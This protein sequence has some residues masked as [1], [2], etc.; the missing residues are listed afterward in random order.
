MSKLALTLALT[1][2]AL[3][4]AAPAIAALPWSAPATIAN[5]IPQLADPTIA[6][7]GNGHAVL[8]ARL[9]TK[10]DGLPSRGFTRLFGQ[11]A[12][13]SFSGR[14]RLVLAAP[15]AAWG[16]SRLALLRLPLAKGNVTIADLAHPQTSLGSSFGRCCG[17][18]EVDPGGYHRLTT[19]ADR[20]SGAIA[21]SE[22]GDVAAV[23]VEHLPGRDHLAVALRRLGQPFGRPSVIAGSGYISSPSVA[24]GAGGDLLVAYQRSVSGRGRVDRRVEARVRRVGHGWAVAQRL[25]ASSGFSEIS[26]AAA[27][28][29]RMVVAWGTQDLGEEANTPWIVRAA[30]RPPGVH[31]FDAAQ[32]LE[33]SEGIARPAGR[34]ATAM[35]PDGTAT[36]AWSGITGT[37]FS[38]SY[39]ARVATAAPSAP[40]SAARTLAPN[41]AVQD[42]AM[43][44]QATALVVWA[45][46]PEPGDDQTTDQVFASLRLAGTPTFAAAEAVSPPERA[47]L[48]RA[49]FD[50]ATGRPAVVWVSRADGVAQ[51][52]RFAARAG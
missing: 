25:G 51:R 23:W 52:L 18:L 46:L 47:S 48:A 26:T 37:A 6:F 5:G 44:D 33:T 36:V 45:T 13:G 40:F 19:R 49:A 20:A 8:S 42:A 10:A 12:D 38:H 30:E 2:L 39:P 35:E 43:S 29:G 41:A 1:G 17:P 7:S 34:V 27:P 4:P 3:V 32:D 50:P 21:A 15:P 11:Q 31:G 14:A 22:R 9:T 28:S 24:Y 16:R